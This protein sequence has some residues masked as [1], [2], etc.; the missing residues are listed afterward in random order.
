MNTETTESYPKTWTRLVLMVSPSGEAHVVEGE[1]APGE[2]G[3][4]LPFVGMERVKHREAFALTRAKIQD[5][6][7]LTRYAGSREDGAKEILRCACITREEV[8]AHLI[9]AED[10]ERLYP[11]LNVKVRDAASEPRP[12]DTSRE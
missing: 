7:A 9:H 12:L 8:D 1:R 2:P 10:R 5:A 4:D 11:L 6:L 3:T